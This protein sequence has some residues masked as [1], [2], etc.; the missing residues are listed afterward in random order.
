MIPAIVAAAGESRRMGRSKP[1]LE[2]EGQPLIGKLVTE[3]LHGGGRPVVVVCPPDDDPDG[4]RVALVAAGAGAVVIVPA[5]RPPQMK[6]SIAMALPRVMQ[7]GE[8][9]G[10]MLTPADRPGIT[11]YVVALLLEHWTRRPEAI[12][13]PTYLGRRAHPVVLPWRVAREIPELP[14]DSGVN[15]LL[16]KY[17]E[18]VWELELP[19]P[20]LLADLNTPED[21][22][23]WQ[24]PSGLRTALAATE[25]FVVQVR[26]FALTRE[27]AGRAEV[28]V[29]LPAGANIRDLRAALAAQH[30]PLGELARN[31]MIALDSE[32]APDTAL[33]K[34]DAKIALIP[35]VSGG[36]SL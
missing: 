35:P 16:T 6:D 4:P 7:E 2:I 31:V 25:Q 32:Y 12:V 21:L 30:P 33:V 22:D 24:N 18:T 34:P 26:L 28:E 13:V 17:R 1:L 9:A 23:R 29:V 10:L 19:L 27:R 8:P 11:R 3:L 5:A 15:H 36:A 14:Q 20:E